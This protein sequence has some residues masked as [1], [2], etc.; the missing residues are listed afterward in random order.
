[1]VTI[2]FALFAAGC[3]SGIHETTWVKMQGGILAG[4]R[5]QRAESALALLDGRGRAVRVQ[6]L[7]SEAICANSW[8]D[9]TVFVTRALVDLLDKQELAA[10]MAHEMGHLLN[11]GHLHDVVSLRG[12]C[13]SP[14]AEVRAD[15]TGLE[16]LR[17]Q[18]VN[19]QVM[20][21]MLRKVKGAIAPS[22]PCQQGLATRI[23][24]LVARLRITPPN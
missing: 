22:S 4:D 3:A 12:C 19:P 18:N 14:D 6:V 9:G 17:A 2:P 10:A 15:A 21:S 11:D 23:D 8:P 20:V 24:L 13:V 16:L 1:M 7:N 5:Q